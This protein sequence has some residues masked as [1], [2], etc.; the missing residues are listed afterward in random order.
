MTGTPL[1][2]KP[3]SLL[4]IEL[5]DALTENRE[6]DF[7]D[8]VVEFGTRLIQEVFR[9]KASMKQQCQR[10]DAL[11]NRLKD[12]EQRAHPVTKGWF[13]VFSSDFLVEH[14][15]F[16]FLPRLRQAYKELAYAQMPEI[17]SRFDAM[18]ARVTAVYEKAQVRGSR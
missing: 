13:F 2:A 6:Q 16:Q 11:A 12:F 4:Y 10:W 5:K 14:S 9:G 1:P 7:M 15:M 18:N 3:V 17:A 8:A